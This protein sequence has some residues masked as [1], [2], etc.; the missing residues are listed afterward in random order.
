[1]SMSVS[2]RIDATLGVVF[3]ALQG[4]VTD[5]DLLQRQRQLA[6]DPQF[7]GNPLVAPKGFGVAP[8]PLG[9]CRWRHGRRCIGM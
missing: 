1:M 5:Q 3:S 4:R 6:D 2:Y 9:R 8:T 7:M